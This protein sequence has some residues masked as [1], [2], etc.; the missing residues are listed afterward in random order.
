LKLMKPLSVYVTVFKT[1]L[2]F[3]L[4]GQILLIIYKDKKHLTACFFLKR[5]VNFMQFLVGVPKG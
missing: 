3:Y 2:V 1:N 4:S 5:S